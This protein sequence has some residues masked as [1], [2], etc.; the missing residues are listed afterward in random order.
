MI[1]KSFSSLW[2]VCDDL[3]SGA[4]IEQVSLLGAKESPVI[5]CSQ[6]VVW[7]GPHNL[8]RDFAA[9][10]CTWQ[11]AEEA[12]Q[13]VIALPAS[14]SRGDPAENIGALQTT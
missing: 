6:A 8:Q 10:F 4:L 5:S 11:G 7:Q 12:G 13:G 2:Y 3:S 1:R 14:A 9:M